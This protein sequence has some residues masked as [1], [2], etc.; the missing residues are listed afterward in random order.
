[1]LPIQS[2][3]WLFRDDTR[4][5]QLHKCNTIAPTVGIFYK[6]CRALGYCLQ[7]TGIVVV[8]SKTGISLLIAQCSLSLSAFTSLLLII[9]QAFCRHFMWQLNPTCEEP[10]RQGRCPRAASTNSCD[11][12]LTGTDGSQGNTAAIWP[13]ALERYVLTSGMPEHEKA[14]VLESMKFSFLFLATRAG[15]YQVPL[16]PDKNMVY[17]L[18]FRKLCLKLAHQIK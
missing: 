12:V 8:S 14:C 17:I 5:C 4:K 10:A 11:Q 18:T 16:T 7:E 9:V 6:S 13:S 15:S 1:M 3:W 2:Q